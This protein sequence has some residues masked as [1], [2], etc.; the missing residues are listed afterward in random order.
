M[1]NPL[2][3]MGKQLHHKDKK[4]PFTIDATT[5]PKVIDFDM[6]GNPDLNTVLEGIYKL[7]GDRL[8]ICLHI[9]KDKKE[10]PTDFT[11]FE[12]SNRIVVQLRRI[13]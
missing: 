6:T 10:R 12:G 5:T 11:T 7:D 13:K 1:E 9:T 8:T 3:F 2:K 4:I